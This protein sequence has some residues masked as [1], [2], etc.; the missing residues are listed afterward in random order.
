[1]KQHI[2]ARVEP[3]VLKG[4]KEVAKEQN[5]S[6]NNFLETALIKETNRHHAKII[7]NEGR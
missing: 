3:E 2:T 1:M 6:F 4:A 5:R 7:A